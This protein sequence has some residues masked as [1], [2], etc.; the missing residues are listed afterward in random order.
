VTAAAPAGGGAP[1]GWLAVRGV[2]GLLR[3]EVLL[4]RAGQ[5]ATVGRGSGSTLPLTRSAGYRALSR[6]PAALRAHCQGVSRRHLRIS[7]PAPGEAE[8][9]DLSRAGTWLDG[10][11]L[12]APARVRDLRARA[13]EVRFG[14]GERLELR[15]FDGNGGAGAP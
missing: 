9:E 1:R 7:V 2:E 13:H 8:V 10:S 4:L 6:D 5:E 11:R 3:G 15:W 14:R 12:A